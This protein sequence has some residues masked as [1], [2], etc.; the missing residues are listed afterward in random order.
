VKRIFVIV[1]LWIWVWG[2]LL[3]GYG[4]PS[5]KAQYYYLNGNPISKSDKEEIY[6]EDK[7]VKRVKNY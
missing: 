6:Q 1:W 2:K 7:L 5:K 3:A 4:E